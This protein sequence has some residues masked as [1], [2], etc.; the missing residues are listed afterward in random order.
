MELLTLG[1]D[2]APLEAPLPRWDSREQNLLAQMLAE[3]MEEHLRTLFGLLALLYPPADIWAAHR[4]LLSGK[5]VLRTH[6]LEY[7]EN[8]LSGAVRR[9]VFAVI[10]DMPV[11]E[12]LR[13]ASREFRVKRVSLAEAVERL[14]DDGH[15]GDADAR[16]LSVAALYTVYTEHLAEIYPKVSALLE[17]TTDPLVRETAAWVAE[18]LRQPA[19]PSPSA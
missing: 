4:S 16:A 3:R 13:L 12:K 17:S 10:G 8:T 15:D 14:L 6:A 11:E 2:G 19:S 5:R 18:G 1:G 7:L 9:N